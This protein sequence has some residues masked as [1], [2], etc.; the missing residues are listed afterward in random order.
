MRRALGQPLDGIRIVDLT[1]LYPGPFATLLLGDLGADVVKLE[2]PRGGDGARYYQP[3]LGPTGAMFAGLNRNKR[4]LAVDLKAAGGRAVFAA[5]LESADVLME[6]FRPGVLDRLGFDEDRLAA[7]YPE[8]IVCS[9]TGYGQTGPAT[10]EAGHDLNYIARAGLLHATGTRS[11]ALAIPGFQVADIAGGALYAVAGV[12]AALLKHER[13][14]GASR[15]D[16]SMTDGAVSFLLPGLAMLAGGARYH[17]PAGEILTGGVP[18]YQVYET[19]DGGH[20]ALGALEPKFW[21]AFCAAVGFETTESHG[22]LFGEN[23]AALE[24]ALREWLATRTMAEWQEKLDG[25]DA[26]CVPVRRPDEVQ[27]DPLFQARDLFFAIPRAGTV[28]LPQVATPLTPADRG[29]FRPPP[30]LGEHTTE[31]LA[32]LGWD[33]AAA[34]TLAEQGVVLASR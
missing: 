30:L 7:D 1:R 21:T 23:G 5:L 32:E 17:G 20:L 24:T 27:D 22:I 34:K 15:L 8:L 12:L 19:A 25:V 28:P 6:S 10:D 18:C 31:L 14:G 11:G 16:V 9:I 3:M 29:A 2:D 26:C 33:A 13:G 4:S